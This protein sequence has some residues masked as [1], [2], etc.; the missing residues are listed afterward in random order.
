M[1]FIATAVEATALVY[2]YKLEKLQFNL[3]EA[4]KAVDLRVDIEFPE[5]QTSGVP[6]IWVE[7]V[8][9][10]SGFIDSVQ[11]VVTSM[12]DN[13]QW[14]GKCQMAGRRRLRGFGSV[15]VPISPL[16]DDLKAQ[17]WLAQGQGTEVR[18]YA[19]A[20]VLAGGHDTISKNSRRYRTSV[21]GDSGNLSPLISD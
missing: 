8:G 19:S 13:E 18:A 2:I 10:G 16:L 17:P 5:G 20:A 9:A 15:A 11:L 1:I 12:R 14:I 4:R 3:G 6:M 7:N 21:T